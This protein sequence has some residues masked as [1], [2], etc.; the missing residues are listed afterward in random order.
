M[1]REQCCELCKVSIVCCSWVT[2]TA[3]PTLFTRLSLFLSAVWVWS[4]RWLWLLL[5][6]QVQQQTLLSP[7]ETKRSGCSLQGK[8]RQ[9]WLSQPLA[10]ISGSY[11]NVVKPQ[12][13]E[14]GRV[15]SVIFR[16]VIWIWKIWR[17]WVQIQVFDST[18]TKLSYIFVNFNTILRSKC[19]LKPSIWKVQISFILFLSFFHFNI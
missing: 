18:Q 14:A 19:C 6:V 9:V 5:L 8:N 11:W 15:Q 3:C 13:L 7:S 2:V 17:S 4:W 1:W 16:A 10:D 12:E